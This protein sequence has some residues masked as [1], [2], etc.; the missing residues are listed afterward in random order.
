MTQLFIRE[1]KI[2]VDTIVLTGLR[3]AFKITKTLRPSPN[4]CEL[5]IFNLNPTHRDQ[6][7]QLQTATVKIDA[8]YAGAIA[9]I[10]QGE[11]RKA[12][13]AE[14]GTSI[15][16]S[17]EGADG[18][19]RIRTARVS[20][21][22]GAGTGLDAVLGH[23]AGALG[24]D[25][26]NSS[27]AFQGAAFGNGMRVFAEGTAVDGSAADALTRIASAA[28]LEWSVQGGALQVLPRGRPLNTPAVVLTPD[29]GLVGSPSLDTTGIM[30]AKT[31]L[32]SDLVPGRLVN[33]TTRFVTGTYRVDKVEITG[34]TEGK[35]WHCSIEGRAP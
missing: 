25:P 6:I 1:A 34:D 9:T 28:G 16:T 10:F 3:V 29:T 17:L 27:R 35:D 4:T 33:V 19:R 5:R 12:R 22:F 15:V 32:M 20:R 23:I 7:E 26:G 2:Q 13:S 30:K 31:F 14:D 8:G 18:E 11:L 21:S 24:V